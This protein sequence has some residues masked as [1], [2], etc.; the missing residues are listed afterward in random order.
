ME[1]VDGEFLSGFPVGGDSHDQS[2]YGTMRHLV[3]GMQRELVT[4]GNRLDERR[5]GLLSH[6]S[7]GL[8]IQ[9]VAQC[10]W[11]PFCVSLAHV[12]QDL[13]N[14]ALPNSATHPIDAVSG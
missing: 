11:R 5:P 4:R 10:C 14:S 1:D 9:H 3:E 7:L 6:R 8:A 2:E 12:G 13:E